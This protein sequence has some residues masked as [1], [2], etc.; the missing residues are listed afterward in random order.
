V[1][2][3]ERQVSQVWSADVRRLVDEAV[4]CYNA[5]AIRASIAATWTAVIAEIIEKIIELADGGD[6][7]AASF[8]ATVDAARAQG[9]T[10][11][12]VPAMQKI[13]DKLLVDAER[14]ELIDSIGARELNRIREDRNLSVHP[15]LRHLGETYDPRPEV[16]RAHLA[17]ALSTVLVHPPTQGRKA[18]EDFTAYVSTP[19]F[20]AS[21]GHIQTTF[22]DRLRNATRRN[23]VKVAAKH[24]LCEV[25]PP[26]GMPVTP[27][28]LAERVAET[29]KPFAGR[30]R[31]VV[32]RTLQ[33]LYP[34]FQALGIETQLR[35]VVRLGDQGL[36]LGHDRA[37][38]GG[39]PRR[40][41]HCRY[42]SSGVRAAAG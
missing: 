32:R 38:D 23:I 16:A 34:R 15:S 6:A 39:T 4:R 30:D 26:A 2:D 11:A 3:L 5:G 17:V 22:F 8:R 36:L 28:V 40:F 42:S 37:I 31:D 27:Q 20:A 41:T 35:A 33:G 10:P 13:E 21:E 18:L 12:G 24:A 19:Y 29:I 7:D 25:P 14:F 9:I 1:T